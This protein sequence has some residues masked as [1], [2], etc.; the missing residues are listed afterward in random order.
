MKRILALILTVVLLVAL[1]P[2][3]IVAK[4]ETVTK[5]PFYFVN[6]DRGFDDGEYDYVYSM[7]YTWINTGNLKDDTAQIN[8][9][10]YFNGFSTSNVEEA[11]AEMYDLF[12]NRPAGSRY[13]NLAAMGSVFDKYVKAAVD[14]E[15]GVELVR[16]WVIRFLDAYKALGGEL[17]GIAID[18]EYNYAYNFYI[19]SYHYNNST[20]SKRNRNIYNDIVANKVYQERIRPK[21]VEYEK[22]G[23][24][25]FYNNPD[26]AKYPERSEIWTMYRYDKNGGDA[27][28]RSTWNWVISGLLTEYINEAVYEPMI[29][30]YP[31]AILSDYS[32]GD[33][34]SWYKTMSNSGDATGTSVR[35]GNASNGVYYGSQFS[36]YYWASYS[37]S[38]TR[39]LYSKPASSNEA[40]FDPTDK[41]TR[42]LYDV[43][44][45][46]RILASTIDVM[47]AENAKV[48]VWMPFFYYASIEKSYGWDPY[49]AEV[50]YHMGMTNPE[51]YFGYVIKKEVESRM[52]W[53][54]DADA[55]DFLVALEVN[56]QLL[57]ELTRVAGA[58][59]RKAIVT[60][61]DWNNG[62]ML[63]GM[64]AGGRN[65]WRITPDTTKVSVDAFKVNDRAPTFSVNGVTI[66]FPQGRIIEDSTISK[67]GTC[68]YWVETPA[69]V[70]PVITSS[71]NRYGENPSFYEDFSNYKTGAFADSSSSMLKTTSGRPDTYWTATGNAEIKANGSNQYLSLSGTS[72]LTNSKI[73]EHITAGDYYAKQQAWEVTVTLPDG[74]YGTVT[75]LDAGENDGGIQIA[76]GKVYYDQ[77][78]AYQE[79]SGLSLS[80]G[81]YVFKREVDFRTEGGFK[82][83]YV[84]YDA[85]GNRLGGVDGV[86]MAIAAIPVTTLEFSTT[87][88][89]AAVQLDDYK[90]YPTGLST[91]LDL[92]QMDRGRKITDTGAA[93]SENT[94]YRFTWMN[95]S[96]QYKVARIYDAK[97]GTILKKVEMAP[98]MDGVVSGVF[99]ASASK[100]IVIAVD[101]KDESAP[102]HPNYDNGNFGWTA[103]SESVGL[104]TGPKP[105]NSGNDG[106]T[107]NTTPDN[108]D[109]GNTGT[110]TPNNPGGEEGG[111]IYEEGIVEGTPET[112]PN[113][114]DPAVGE[115]GANQETNA[116]PDADATTE[117]DEKKGLSGGMI[118]L[119][120]GL[121][122]A[123]L[124]G[125][126][127]AVYIF[128]IKPKMAAKSIDDFAENELQQE[129]EE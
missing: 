8:I 66:T 105:A 128:V 19:E 51:P 21:L 71:S 50:F 70:T 69:N 68:G 14:M 111:N 2:T 33:S 10:V 38:K 76:E 116:A 53:K 26:P 123:V 73:V 120:I 46:K 31:G 94:G 4:A 63:S 54:D 20:V 7:P 34:Y 95:A 29:E 90:L 82:C 13:F 5:K 75:L 62:Y 55:G 88:A 65:I 57:G 56:D 104:A 22:Q 9:G 117:P 72:K 74:N 89:A 77:S 27:T 118:A 126:G 12:K 41:F 112:T 61:I 64:Y 100:Q 99:E 15:K 16:D 49:F 45:Q 109:N 92:Y 85:S 129:N 110:V 47:G 108:P 32:R 37:G 124:A 39:Q 1:F 36:E 42:A 91:S 113:A 17:D 40:V 103:V 58:S 35:V 80:A 119:I 60:P 97:S 24:W 93:R 84:V 25:K 98:G 121:S 30:R 23:L 115:N 78:G 102:N 59:D 48:N 44:N 106:N 83:S 3:S 114:N 6:W 125:A 52:E 43:N 28:C 79:L 11:A 127:V 107:G 87:G 86:A 122:V 67:I 101:I 18:L 96:N 81:T